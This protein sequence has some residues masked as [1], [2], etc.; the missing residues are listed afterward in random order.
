MTTSRLGIALLWLVIGAAGAAQ[1]E[2]AKVELHVLETLTLPDEDVL[3]GKRDG[4]RAT[5]TA[6]LRIPAVGAAPFPAIVQVHGSGGIFP[7]DERWSR[8]L[9]DLGVATLTI[10]S[11]TGR[12]IIDT[13]TNQ[14]Q[15]G[16]L[17]MLIDAFRGLELLARDSRIDPRRIGVLGGSRGGV[18]A[19]YSSL[20]RFRSAYAAPA[21]RFALH[22]VF[23]TN[24]N[25]KYLGDEL[26]DAPIRFF[27]GDADDI[28]PIEPCREYAER[29][30]RA[31]KDVALLA[32]AGA[33]HGFDN[34]NS[35]GPLRIERAETPGFCLLE[36]TQDARLVL[37]E[38]RVPFTYD[39]PC[40]RRG[41]TAGRDAAAHAAAVEDLQRVVR[42][43]F[44][45]ESAERR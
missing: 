37:R 31:G 44:G 33:H 40:V 10:D 5:L 3:A 11:F 20:E 4:P 23:Y 15:L 36:E 41:L 18:P 38:T 32:Y 2:P 8:E 35:P 26:L 25:T 21:T 14:A 6:L 30:R 34:P 29:L 16:T 24:C 17:T 9:N 43:V 28:A 7:A 42:G 45:L 27:H 39:A 1:A 13:V 19:L 12:G 22:L